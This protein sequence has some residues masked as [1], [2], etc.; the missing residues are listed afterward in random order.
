MLP[1]WDN[2][3]IG[4]NWDPQLIFRNWIL[5]LEI[6][7]NW[8]YGHLI[9]NVKVKLSWN[10]KYL[11]QISQDVSQCS[12]KGKKPCFSISAKAC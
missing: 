6:E 2:F 5:A 4:N 3:R 12:L 7:K 10:W 9:V 8:K 11:S 1:I